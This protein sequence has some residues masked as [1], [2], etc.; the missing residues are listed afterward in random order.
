MKTEDRVNELLQL[1][2]NQAPWQARV[3]L[4]FLV[5]KYGFCREIACSA[6]RAYARVIENTEGGEEDKE[7]EK[8]LRNLPLDLAI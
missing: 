7:T 5:S 6:Y 2:M 8:F 1:P 4:A 3:A